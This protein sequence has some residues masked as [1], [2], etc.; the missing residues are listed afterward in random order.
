MFASYVSPSNDLSVEYDSYR[1]I[2]AVV[3]LS[4]ETRSGTLG[5]IS[6]L[7]SA[8]ASNFLTN[9]T[10]VITPSSIAEYAD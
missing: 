7:F 8:V 6:G 2:S 1:P 3:Q 4:C 9:D 10:S 5:D